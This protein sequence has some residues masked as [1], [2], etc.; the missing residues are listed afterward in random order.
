MDI[1]SVLKP[2]ASQAGGGTFVE[3]LVLSGDPAQPQVR[4]HCAAA[5]GQPPQSDLAITSDFITLI[6]VWII[7]AAPRSGHI[8]AT[9]RAGHG[10]GHVDKH[11]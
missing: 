7:A 3:A 6:L 4:G 2:K 1:K 8:A 10:G 11:L 9:A 5:A